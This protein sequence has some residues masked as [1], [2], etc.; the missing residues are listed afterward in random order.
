[1]NPIEYAC[2]YDIE[3]CGWLLVGKIPRGDGIGY[4]FCQEFLE[5][6]RPTYEKM[7]AAVDKIEELLLEVMNETFD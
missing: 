6:S 2:N 3:R 5:G 4:W 7:W 1:M